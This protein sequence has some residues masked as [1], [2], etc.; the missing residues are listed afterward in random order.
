M[1]LCWLFVWVQAICCF[2]LICIQGFV[3]VMQV[4]LQSGAWWGVFKHAWGMG[5]AS[6]AGCA[7]WFCC[8]RISF[9]VNCN[10]ELLLEVSCMPLFVRIL[11][12]FADEQG[13]ANFKNMM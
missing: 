5:I 8:G 9:A 1:V 11:V 7:G 2:V 12:V 4:F 6:F 13:F 3:I 10:W